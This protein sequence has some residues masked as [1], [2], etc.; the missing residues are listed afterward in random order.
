LMNIELAWLERNLL[1]GAMLFGIGLVGAICRRN[2][3]VVFL[4][5]ELVFQGA[6]LSWAGW[7]RW[8]GNVDGQ[9]FVVFLIAV[10]ACEAAIALALFVTIYHHW[11]RLD[12]LLGRQLREDTLPE[13][14]S[15]RFDD[16]VEQAPAPRWPRLPPAGVAPQV[17]P[18]SLNQRDRI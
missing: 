10:A 16:S 8:H 7:A 9:V 6:A 4:S 14:E 2:L 12:V 18:Q 1:L 5:I 13:L 15:E 17:D 11:G 3:I